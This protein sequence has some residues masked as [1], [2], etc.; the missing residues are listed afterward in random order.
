[1]VTTQDDR[2]AAFIRKIIHHGSSEKYRHDVLGYN[3]RMTDLAAAIGIEQLKKVTSF[4][5]KRRENAQ[6]LNENLRT[7][8]GIILPE[9]SEGHIFHQYTIRITPHFVMT[10]DEVQNHL[11]QR[12]IASAIHYPIPIHKQKSYSE[13]NNQSLPIAEKLAREVLSL[14]VHPAL[15]RKDLNKI[16]QAFCEMCLTRRVS[17]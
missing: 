16:I 12:G 8:S 5:K 2:T 17:E 3:Y 11:C 9:V 10:R 7:L 1:M 6:F 13:Y 14:P 4:N 15:T